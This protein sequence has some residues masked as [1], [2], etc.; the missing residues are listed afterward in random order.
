M[1]SFSMSQL[2]AAKQQKPRKS[3][4]KPKEP[5]N[6]MSEATAALPL[7]ANKRSMTWLLKGAELAGFGEAE[8]A[9]LDQAFGLICQGEAFKAVGKIKRAVGEADSVAAKAELE[10]LASMAEGRSTLPKATRSKTS[11]EG[12]GRSKPKASAGIDTTVME[13]LM[14]ALAS[15]GLIDLP[16]EI[17]VVEDDEII[18]E[19]DEVED[20]AEGFDEAKWFGELTAEEHFGLA[21]QHLLEG[22]DKSRPMEA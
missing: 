8:L 14:E 6:R 12:F 10:A 15:K 3:S 17:E 16:S 21:L 19:V 4:A 9:I 13:K 7:T 1:A 20:E 11:L 22:I 18:D 5:V 2:A